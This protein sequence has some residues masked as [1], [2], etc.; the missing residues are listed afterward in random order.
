MFATLSTGARRIKGGE[1]MIDIFGRVMLMVVAIE[2][3]GWVMLQELQ[4]KLFGRYVR[5]EKTKSAS[6][7][8]PEKSRNAGS[9]GKFGRRVKARGRGA[10][11]THSCN[12]VNK[13]GLAID[14]CIRD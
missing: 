6:R 12:S 11:F 10:S 1:K 5:D 13:S 14:F 4:S 8:N 3:S 9:R 2:D 7:E